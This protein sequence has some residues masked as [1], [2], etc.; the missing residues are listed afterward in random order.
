SL[1]FSTNGLITFGSGN[2]EFDNSDLTFSPFQA[3]IAPFWDDLDTF[4]GGAV[5]WQGGGA[6]GR[7]H[8]C[9]PWD[10]GKFFFCHGPIT[11]EAV[12]G[13]DGSIQF[14][15]QNLSGGVFQDEGQ[16]AT[17]GVK[18]VGTPP[19]GRLLLSFNSGP[20]TFVGSGQS[21]RLVPIPLPSDL[22]S[23]T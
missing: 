18:D 8:P 19:P 7:Q 9:I 1:Y 23:F 15:Y 2:G 10:N 4:F 11:F 3:A 22:Y 20:N 14:N 21:T 16:S 13:A 6:G 17:V 5:Y 12:L